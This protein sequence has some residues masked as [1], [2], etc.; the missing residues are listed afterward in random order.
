MW[1]NGYGAVHDID[2]RQVLSRSPM[3]IPNWQ[4]LI[5]GGRV[6]KKLIRVVGSTDANLK[7]RQ[8]SSREC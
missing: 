6:S 3:S 5:A 8:K 2:T 1:A 7:K 4:K